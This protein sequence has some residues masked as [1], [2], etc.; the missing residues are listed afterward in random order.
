M[1]NVSSTEKNLVI[2]ILAKSFA[3]NKSV[4]YLIPQDERREMRI[5][6]LMEYSYEVCRTSGK[7]LLSED[8]KACALVLFPDRK[9]ISLQTIFSDFKLIVNGI[10]IGNISKAI[11]REKMVSANY[12]GSEIYYLWFIGVDPDFQSRGI[13]HKLMTEII[14]DAK[15]MNRPIYL[16]T[17]TL[18]NIPWYKKFGLEVYGQLNFTYELFLLRTSSK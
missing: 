15:Q 16:E 8:K 6:S 7:V 5:R 12:P 2:A 18:K 14:E 10:G 1:Q 17:S 3:A 13:G 9:K 4:N 11:N